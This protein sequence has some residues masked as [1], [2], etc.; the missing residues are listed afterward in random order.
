MQKLTLDTY[1]NER[2]MDPKFKKEWEL[3]ELQ[4]QVTRQLIGVRLKKNLSQRKLAE[5]VQT[6]QAVISRI[7]RMSVNPSIGMIERIA[8]ALGQR[9]Q[10]N[11]IPQ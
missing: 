1:I 10:V 7:E 6:T 4:Y 5:K 8:Q 3:S 11:F 2:L 9:I